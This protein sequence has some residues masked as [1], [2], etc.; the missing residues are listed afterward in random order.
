MTNHQKDTLITIHKFRFTGRKR[1]RELS[2]IY[3]YGCVAVERVVIQH[4]FHKRKERDTYTT[5]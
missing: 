5:R 4:K 2:Q 1:M 3:W